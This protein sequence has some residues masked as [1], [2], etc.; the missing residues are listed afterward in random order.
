MRHWA[1]QMR[2]VYADMIA[3][4]NVMTAEPKTLEELFE[5]F[6]RLLDKMGAED[7]ENVKPAGEK[8]KNK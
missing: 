8:E 3:G 6:F 4:T 2:S 7:L 1:P 5:P